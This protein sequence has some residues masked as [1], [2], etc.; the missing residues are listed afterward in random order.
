M[1]HTDHEDT[2]AIEWEDGTEATWFVDLFP[3]KGD[4]VITTPCHGT[5][6]WFDYETVGSPYLS[7]E[8]V[9]SMYCS[10][11]HCY[12]EWDADGT[13]SEFNTPKGNTMK[14]KDSMSSLEHIVL[15]QSEDE[16]KR[17]LEVRCSLCNLH[18]C[19]AEPG[20]TLDLLYRTAADH[21]CGGV[22][23]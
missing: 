19:D 18:I 8:V 3:G 7:Y 21:D 13:P 15:V 20:D 4:M 16:V 14:S 5:E 1:K 11:E 22:T 17:D 23:P 12:N 9:K 2:K 10:A 6:F